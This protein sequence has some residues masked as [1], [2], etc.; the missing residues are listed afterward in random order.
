MHNT[1]N[2]LE[3]A[4]AAFA[5]T[6]EDW[7]NK[8][9]VVRGYEKASGTRSDYV[10]AFIP[11]GYSTLLSVSMVQT[12]DEKEFRH[13]IAHPVMAPFSGVM[14]TSAAVA[15]LRDQCIKSLAQK[16]QAQ[17][18]KHLAAPYGLPRSVWTGAALE[19]GGVSVVVAGLARLCAVDE[20]AA[21]VKAKSPAQMLLGALLP[22]AR[23]STRLNLKPGNFLA[24]ESVEMPEHGKTLVELCAEQLRRTEELRSVLRAGAR[25]SA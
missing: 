24:V 19:E 7:R 12:R 16:I 2:T 22:C 20:M 14:D 11:E 15:A 8:A 18:E 6:A 23:V 5:A 17:H 4:L 1:H 10:F 13:L 9:T 3:A 25:G 21:R